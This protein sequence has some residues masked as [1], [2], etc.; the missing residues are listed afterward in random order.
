MT[1]DFAFGQWIQWICQEQIIPSLSGNPLSKAL[2]LISSVTDNKSNEHNE[3]F[4]IHMMWAAATPFPSSA[5]SRLLVDK[6]STQNCWHFSENPVLVVA[7]FLLPLGCPSPTH[8]CLFCFAVFLSTFK[9]QFQVDHIWKC[10]PP[11]GVPRLPLLVLP[12]FFILDCNTFVFFCSL[13]DVWLLGVKNC[14]FSISVFLMLN[15]VSGTMS[16]VKVVW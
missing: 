3:F 6:P 9:T 10:D 14:D 4:H 8:P 13:L 11:L 12:I 7:R 15:M 1:E 5:T 16:C 2:F